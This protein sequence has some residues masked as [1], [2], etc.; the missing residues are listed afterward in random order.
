MIPLHYFTFESK[1]N[2]G[3]L[4]DVIATCDTFLIDTLTNRR[5]RVPPATLESQM[6][7]HFSGHL[8]NVKDLQNIIE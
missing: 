2:S 3:N 5:R 7:L 8:W 6:L 4:S 1:C